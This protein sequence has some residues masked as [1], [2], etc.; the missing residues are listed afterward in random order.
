MP[1]DCFSIYLSILLSGSSAGHDIATR[2]LPVNVAAYVIREQEMQ[3]KYT[4]VRNILGFVGIVGWFA[5]AAG[6]VI[7]V[8]GI[9]DGSQTGSIGVGAGLAVAMAGLIQVVLS[10]VS[11][12]ILDMADNSRETLALQRA[13]AGSAE[14]S[15]TASLPDGSAAPVLEPSAGQEPEAQENVAIYMGEEI[16]KRDMRYYWM[17]KKFLTLGKA[18]AAIKSAKNAGP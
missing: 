7:L 12:A 18:K 6:L 1:S 16:E 11:V 13:M 3:T 10:Q 17:G 8:I 2:N 15:Q 14:I 9:S 4:S 5:F